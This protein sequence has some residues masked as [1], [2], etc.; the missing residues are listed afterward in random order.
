MH[1]AGRLPI[2]VGGTGLYIR[3]LLE[4]IAPV[5]EIEPEVR[6][7]VRALPV[8]EAWAALAREDPPA[9]ARLPAGD[10]TRVA[11]ALEVVRSTGRSLAAWQAERVGGIGR[12]VALH[13]LILD[14]PRDWLRGRADA[15]YAAMVEAG[16][17]EEA[18]ALAARGLD[19]ALPVM[20]A[21]GVP[22]LLRHLAGELPLPEAVAAGQ[23]ATRQYIKRQATWFA[24]QA[25]A[26]WPRY[27][28][29][30]RDVKAPKHAI[31]LQ[32]SALTY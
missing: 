13:P 24:H 1:R 16:G 30:L 12:R 21:I 27:A 6:A 22:P 7:R 26:E 18:A 8:A 10:R 20:C 9:A 25:P 15:R 17:L 4:G 31:L 5:P 14:P 3:T 28:E 11:R 23:A 19:P 32:T 29:P 2:L